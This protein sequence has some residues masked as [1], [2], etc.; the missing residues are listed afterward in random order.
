[1][2]SDMSDTLPSQGAYNKKRLLSNKGSK[3]RHVNDGNLRKSLDIGATFSTSVTA[4]SSFKRRNQVPAVSRLSAEGS[5]VI[6]KDMSKS[7]S[8]NLMNSEGRVDETKSISS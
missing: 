8:F 3:Y 5:M 7:P 6:R 1:M 4:M 2:S